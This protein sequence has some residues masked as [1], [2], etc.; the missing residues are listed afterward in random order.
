MTN[1][2]SAMTGSCWNAKSRAVG[3]CDAARSR[4]ASHPIACRLLIALNLVITAWVASAPRA[5]ADSSSSVMVVYSVDGSNQPK[6]STWSGSAWSSGSSLSSVGGEANWVIL[7]NCPTRNEMACATFDPASDVNVMFFNGSSWSSPVEV[8]INADEVDDRSV[9]IAYE[10]LSGDALVVYYD[11]DE[12]NFGYRTYNGTTLSSETDLARS[13]ITG[14]DYVLLVSKPDSDQIVLITLGQVSGNGEVISANIWNGSSWLG[15]T[16]IES[17]APTNDNE[18]FAFCFESIS[19]KGLLVYGESGQSQPRYRTLTGTSWS[20]EA[21]VPSVG[22]VPWWMRLAP[23][24]NSNSVLFASLDAANDVNVNVWN[25]TSWGSN[26]QV[27][28]NAPGYAQRYFDIAFEPG[29]AIGLVAYVESGQSSLRYRTWNGTSWS[30]EQ[31]GTNLGNQG[32]TIALTPGTSDQEIFVAATDDG[33]D[34]EVFRWTGSGFTSTTQ[35]EGTVGGLSSTEPFMISVPAS[36]PLVPANTPYAHDF[37][38]SMGAEWSAG[39]RSFVS[40][41]TNFAGRHHSKPLKLALNTTPGETYTVM[42]DFYAIDSWDGATSNN[43]SAPDFFSVSAGSTQIFSHTLTHEWPSTRAGSYPY[44]YDQIGDYG[45]NSWHKDAI[46]RKMQATFIATDTTTTLSFQGVVTDENS[47]GVDDE[48]WGIDNIAVDV[49]R[50]VDVSSA[51]GFNVSTS[52]AFDNFGGGMS[53]GD[54]DNDGDLDCYISGNT[55]RLLK[56]NDAGAS[57]TAVSLGDLRRQAAMVD[58]DNDG[59]L[60]L[61]VATTNDFNTE[62]CMLNNGSASFTSGGNLGFSGPSNNENCAAA[63]VNADGWPDIVMFS[64]NGNWIGHHTGSTSPALSGTNASS[65]GLHTSRNYGNG[66]YSSTGD[67]NHDGRVDFFYHYGGGRLFCSNGDGT[68]TYNNRNIGISTG[69]SLK[70]GSAWG[71]YDND[72]DLDLATARMSEACSGYL[73]RNDCFTSNGFTGNFTNVTSSAGLS[74]NT[75]VDYGPDDKP[76]TRSVAWGDYDNDGDLDLFILGAKGAH[77][78]YQNQGNGTFAR[79]AHGINTSGTFIDCCFVDYDNDGDLDLALTREN[80][81]A[82]LYRNRTNNTSYLKVCLAGRGAGGTPK[83]AIGTR[84]ELWNASGTQRLARRDIGVAR[85]YGGTEPIW[86]HFGGVNPSTE[87]QLKVYFATTTT[88]KTVRPSEASTTIGT[89]TIPQMI[90]ISESSPATIMKW[91]E[92]VNKPSL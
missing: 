91:K 54:F 69:E 77:Y 46:F 37:E 21:S 53:W 38:S 16:T 82:M 17:S 10:Q 83:D 85:G 24:P 66:D 25:G 48:S 9:D 76:G 27:E 6:A 34:L 20:S 61:W 12:N 70:L 43:N 92:N 40:T 30:S 22:S 62:R 80:G 33:N 67:I 11:L 7:K 1:L 73:W 52:T 59:D 79:V 71:D 81:T 2:T 63:D 39:T 68:F 56:N 42:F 49:A 5:C 58:I 19:G 29:G 26:V 86:A 13:G 65:Y 75:E 35:L 90:S 51:A 47:A 8:C 44:S 64:E 74:V 41:F 31:T 28:T 57:F 87:Y 14:N 55:A 50:F 89:R 72:G 45:Y 15:W 78:L 32:R 23:A 36:R 4:A 84:V 60:D 18:C 3:P 88:V